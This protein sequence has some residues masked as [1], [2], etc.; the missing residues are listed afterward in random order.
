MGDSQQTRA[1]IKDAARTLFVEAGYE[2]T[3]FAK[4][5]NNAKA[6]IGSINNFFTDK[7]SLARELYMEATTVLAQAVE[8]A[9]AEPGQTIEANVRAAQAA[10][11][12]WAKREEFRL[13]CRLDGVIKSRPDDTQSLEQRLQAILV[14]WAATKR[15]M[16]HQTAPQLYAAIFAP[17]QFAV[18]HPEVWTKQEIDWSHMLAAM[19]VAALKL[20]IEPHAAKL[21]APKSA[22]QGAQRSLFARS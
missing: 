21:S 9:L 7:P 19:A 12:N 22:R 15:P 6:S 2:G 5:A 10:Y 14:A 8:K 1:R 3:T 18:R 11:L 13:L 16:L 20:P 17:A 4:L